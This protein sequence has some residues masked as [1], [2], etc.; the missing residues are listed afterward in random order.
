MIDIDL[1]SIL[2][3]SYKDLSNVLMLRVKIGNFTEMFG[4]VY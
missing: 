3:I 2:I 1:F 4:P